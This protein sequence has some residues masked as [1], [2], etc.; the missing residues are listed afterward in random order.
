M[1]SGNSA[2]AVN[3]ELRAAAPS[4]DDAYLKQDITCVNAVNCSLFG[5]C[6]N[7]HAQPL[8]S[9]TPGTLLGLQKNTSDNWSIASVRWT[10]ADQQQRQL[11]IEIVGQSAT[12][13]AIKI[14]HSKHGTDAMPALYIPANDT[15]SALLAKAESSAELKST[16]DT[17]TKVTQEDW[18]LF[19][20]TSLSN[21]T[22]ALLLMDEK[23]QRII[24]SKC[25]EQTSE[26]CVYAVNL[27][28]QGDEN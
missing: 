10:R 6:V 28:E 12:P 23:I 7:G 19:P 13:C 17:L 3:L 9:Y 4:A 14:V 11:G 22:S 21:K 8:N 18:L 1:A 26:Y 2:A 27:A 5:L 15:K 24:L 16:E 20:D 25:I